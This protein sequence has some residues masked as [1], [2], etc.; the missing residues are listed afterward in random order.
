MQ[1]GKLKQAVGSPAYARAWR[2]YPAWQRTKTLKYEN[3]RDGGKD[4]ERYT[5]VLFLKGRVI[6][7]N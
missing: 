6:D 3:D 7:N 1:N 5:I 4:K 2:K